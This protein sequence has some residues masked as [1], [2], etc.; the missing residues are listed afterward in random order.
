MTEQT[1]IAPIL[2]SSG[3]LH[4]AS[5]TS[6]STVQDVI[7]SLK[8]LEDVCEEVLGDW[9]YD[10]WALQKIRKEPLGR[11]WEDSELETLSIGKAELVIPQLMRRLMP[12]SKVF[13]LR[14]QP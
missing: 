5:I 3:S 6:K 14:R 8:V 2:L 12:R 1:T 9:R 13:S 11:L 7:D 4:F 10:E